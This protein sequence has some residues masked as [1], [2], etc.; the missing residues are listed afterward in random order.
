MKKSKGSPFKDLNILVVG[1]T[2]VDEYA[3]AKSTRVSPEAFVRVL[4]D[5]KTE[6]KKPGLAGNVVECLRALGAKAELLTVVGTDKHGDYLVENSTGGY[7]VRDTDRPT[8]IKQRVLINGEHFCRNDIEKTHPLSKDISDTFENLLHNKMWDYD[9]ILLQDYG[10]GLWTDAVLKR[11]FAC[12]VKSHVKVFVDPFSGRK[13]S[14]YKG[15]Y[16]I[17]ANQDEAR[18]MSKMHENYSDAE[19]SE[20]LEN[21]TGACVIVTSGAAGAS[22]SSYVTKPRKTKIEVIDVS[23]CG[24]VALAI[25]TLADLIGMKLSKAME[26][27][28]QAASL[29]CSKPMGESTV[30]WE[31]I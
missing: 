25:L 10:K 19:V 15:A 5:M 4:T 13:L 26:L 30:R 11:F 29:K 2:G 20:Y 8:I 1:E 17:K 21:K 23:G 14:S 22:Q 18:R 24:D 31:E 3:F 16:L 12:A 28:N 27:A 6:I 7:F 9:A